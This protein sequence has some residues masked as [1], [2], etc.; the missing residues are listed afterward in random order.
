MKR[1]EILIGLLLLCAV[2]MFSSCVKDDVDVFNLQSQGQELRFNAGQSQEDADKFT[3]SGEAKE[4]EDAP[5]TAVY[6]LEGDEDFEEP[7][8]LHMTSE[9]REAPTAETMATR[10]APVTSSEAFITTYGADGFGLFAY[11]YPATESW[12]NKVHTSEYV[13]NEK[14]VYYGTVEDPKGK[15]PSRDCNYWAIKNPFAYTQYHWPGSNY[16]IRF[17]TYAP[18][19]HSSIAVQS[20]VYTGEPI[21]TY[22]VDETNGYDSEY[23]LLHPDFVVAQS[24]DYAG[25][26][27]QTI[28]LSF[29]HALTAVRFRMGEDMDIDVIK[30]IA[31]ENVYRQGK[32]TLTDDMEWSALAEKGSV[33]LTKDIDISGKKNEVVVLEND[34]FMMLPQTLPDDAQV[35]I[36]FIDS[37]KTTRTIRGEIGGKNWDMGYLVTYDI[38]QR[39]VYTTATFDVSNPG[40]TT[41]NYQGGFTTYTVTSYTERKDLKTNK[42]DIVAAPWVAE[43]W[44]GTDWVTTRPE[45]FSAFTP[46]GTGGDEIKYGITVAPQNPVYNGNPLA[47]VAAVGTSDNPHDLSN[48]T[49]T[50]VNTANCYIVNAPGVY[51]LPLVYGNGIENGA[52]N[53]NSYKWP[54]GNMHNYLDA[55]I[56]TPLIQDDGITIAD[57]VLV[58]SDEVDLVKVSSKT[59]VKRMAVANGTDLNWAKTTMQY[60]QF[61]V[62]AESIMPGNAIVAIRDAD[63]RIIWSWHIW[64]TDF[65]PYVAGSTTALPTVTDGSGNSYTYDLM[66]QNLG[67]CPAKE[68]TWAARSVKYRIRQETTGKTKE[69]TLNQTAYGPET[70]TGNCPY[71]QWGRKDPMLSFCYANGSTAQEKPCYVPLG[72][73]YKFQISTVTSGVSM[74][75]S[76]QNPH[77][78]YPRATV[79]YDWCTTD[80][81]ELARWDGTNTLGPTT[82]INGVVGNKFSTNNDFAVRKTIYD[83]S[84]VSYCMPPKCAFRGLDRDISDASGTY[85]TVDG[86]GMFTIENI[87][88]P[89]TGDRSR[90][91]GASWYDA[92]GKIGEYWTSSPVYG[93]DQSV[94]DGEWST[95]FESAAFF[96]TRTKTAS[97]GD[98]GKSSGFAV[99]CIKQK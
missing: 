79:E 35:V 11:S 34:Y 53:F 17:Y 70:R 6:E 16:K 82:L 84:P 74:G 57:A 44:N 30:S 36:T 95:K 29:K 46:R 88:F 45:F 68:V 77:V 40:A 39:Y 33:T 73:S 76:I 98:M 15:E 48:P 75:T 47:G 83:P 1:F 26:T 8:Y 18:Y 24:E 49:G 10:G 12:N 28:A 72:G 64:V 50:E 67:W 62:P 54:S 19:N 63:K 69:V 43:F 52:C 20:S 22:T 61:E 80:D 90:T 7:L 89:T 55:K 37:S 14:V 9:K 78:F 60:L 42:T 32:L 81:F 92:S 59:V 65:N 58:Y 51:I 41:F 66:N 4:C 21:I 3:R 2:L 25:D 93:R 85:S 31:F 97:L 56:T 5:Q 38:T 71:Y 27:N 94:T 96:Q 91:T 87:K 13:H 99:R 23:K 86:S